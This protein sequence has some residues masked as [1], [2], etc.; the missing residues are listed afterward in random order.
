MQEGLPRQFNGWSKPAD[1]YS[2]RFCGVSND[3][4]S[5]QTNRSDD[6]SAIVIK[7]KWDDAGDIVAYSKE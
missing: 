3:S 7:K 4:M 2:C 5:R 6:H 1:P